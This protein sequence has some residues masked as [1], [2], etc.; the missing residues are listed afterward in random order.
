MFSLRAALAFEIDNGR[1]A[2]DL[3]D[4]ALPENLM[5]HAVAFIEFRHISRFVADIA[6]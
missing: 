1:V 2:F 5:A 6:G 3:H 4:R